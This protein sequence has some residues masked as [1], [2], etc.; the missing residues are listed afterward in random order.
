[1]LAMETAL[2]SQM[3]LISC[4]ISY[5]DITLLST[6]HN[7]GILDEVQYLDEGVFVRGKIPLFLKE[8]IN[9][10]SLYDE[11]EKED[12]SEGGDY[13]GK[14]ENSNDDEDVD[15]FDVDFDWS[16]MAKGRHSARLQWDELEGDNNSNN[17]GSDLFQS[18]DNDLSEDMIPI[19]GSVG[20][21]G[22]FQKVLNFSKE[23]SRNANKKKNKTKN[24]VG[25]KPLRG[26]DGDEFNDTSK[27]LDF[28][29][30]EY[31]E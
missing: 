21:R 24:V 7:L 20:Y 6:V 14:K 12:S 1:M 5:T 10:R 26:D 8:Q 23:S 31:S 11:N 9:N 13:D 15:I 16:G 19:E 4:T 30:G 2:S 18:V 22:A 17:N 25:G 3:E 29:G 28:D 27:L